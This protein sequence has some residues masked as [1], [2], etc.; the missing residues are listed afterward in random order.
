MSQVGRAGE[1]SGGICPRGRCPILDVYS[2][3]IYRTIKYERWG[4]TPYFIHLEP[5]L[6]AASSIRKDSGCDL[7]ESVRCVSAALRSPGK[8]NTTRDH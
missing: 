3:Y 2:I 1:M 4:K 8:L 7:V 5:P 6:W